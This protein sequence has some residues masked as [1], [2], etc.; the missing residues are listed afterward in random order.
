MKQLGTIREIT[1]TVERCRQASIAQGTP[2]HA[3][4]LAAVLGSMGLG[5]VGYWLEEEISVSP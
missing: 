3:D 5:L 1:E 2:F 4:A